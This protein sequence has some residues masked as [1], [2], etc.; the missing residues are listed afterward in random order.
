MNRYDGNP[1]LRLLDC[2]ILDAIG[3][4]GGDQRETL[5]VLEPKPNS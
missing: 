4:L 1:F 5:A 2:C 3:E